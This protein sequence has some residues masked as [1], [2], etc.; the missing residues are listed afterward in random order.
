MSVIHGV[1]LYEPYCMYLDGVPPFRVWDLSSV[2][3]TFTSY[4]T[5]SC[6]VAAQPKVETLEYVLRESK[7][8]TLCSQT[9]SSVISRGIIPQK[10]TTV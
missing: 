10:Y 1:F 7:R 8:S 4:P 2:T 5:H 6:T 3:C 9:V